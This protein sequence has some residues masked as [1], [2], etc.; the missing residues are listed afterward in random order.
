MTQVHQAYLVILDVQGCKVA[1][2]PRDLLE[3]KVALGQLVALDLSGYV[4]LK[5]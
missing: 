5:V 3:K 1:K 4:V 2:A